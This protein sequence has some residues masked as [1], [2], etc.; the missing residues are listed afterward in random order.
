MTRFSDKAHDKATKQLLIHKVNNGQ[1]HNSQDEVAV[2]EPLEIRIEFSPLGL[3]KHREQKSISITM[4]TPGYDFE[5]AAGFLLTE[6]IIQ[7]TEQIKTIDFCGPAVGEEQLNNTVKVSLQ[8]NVKVDLKRLERHFYTTSSCGVCGKTSLEALYVQGQQPIDHDNFTI[9]RESL[10]QLANSLKQHQTIFNKTG[11]IHAA[12]AFNSQAQILQVREDV[13]RHNALD[14]LIGHML[15]NYAK[16]LTES[17]SNYGILV[18]GRASFELLQKAM[19]ARSPL[20][21]AVG[22]PS[23][24]AVELAEAFNITLI[25]FLSNNRFNI[26]SG[27]QR[28]TDH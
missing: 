9:N 12:A 14:K 3:N 28:I 13:G 2:E 27:S 16:P 1:S 19:M 24:L 6:G 11:G 23:S 15:L 20:L 7:K 18:S 21:L 25:G 26:Y 10:Y 4:R 17:L 22:A 5:L 8:A